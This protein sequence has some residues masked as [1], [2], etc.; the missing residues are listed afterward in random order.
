MGKKYLAWQ[1]SWGKAAQSAMLNV[2]LN[3]ELVF[4]DWKRVFVLK[5]N[6][7]LNACTAL[8]VKCDFDILRSLSWSKSMGLERY[9]SKPF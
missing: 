6:I 3:A 9:L 7:E 4:S 5:L 8:W 1:G 2:I